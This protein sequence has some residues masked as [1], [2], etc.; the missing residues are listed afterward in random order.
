VDGGNED[1]IIKKQWSRASQG[2]FLYKLGL[3]LSQG[4]SINK[5]IVLLRSQ[6]NTTEKRH[7]DKSLEVLDDGNPLIEVFC[8]MNL[9]NEVISSLA[10]NSTNGNLI[11][12]LLENG[13]YMKKKSEWMKRLTKTV[14]YPLFLLFLTIWIGFL[15]YHFLFPQFSL[16][17]TSLEIKTPVFTSIMISML[18][19]IPLI[20][21]V[22]LCALLIGCGSIIVARK[23]IKSSTRMMIV[24]SIPLLNKIFKLMNSHFFCVNFGS[25]L[26]SGLPVTDALIVLEQQMKLGFFKEESVRIQKGLMDGKTLPDL[27]R[28]K[29][30]YVKELA[31]IV[32]FGQAHG[33]LGSD[34][35]QY[36][37]WLFIELEEKLLNA[38]QKI[39]PLLFAVIGGFVLLLFA[40]MLL[41]M[42]NLMEAL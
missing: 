7:L 28:N 24:T 16:L 5:S 19:M 42:F 37:E 8:K 20:G 11:D 12:S 9:P 6:L 3:L 23:K 13:T 38:I 1:V 17:F 36:G 27:L 30:F 18:A 29:P 40:S 14:K 35:V 10:I 34:L 22:G 25:M 31:E 21:L 39:Q 41:P 33:K 4:Y 15:F 2:A 26:K 32:H